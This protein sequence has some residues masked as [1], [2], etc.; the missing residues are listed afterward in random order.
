MSQEPVF[1][2]SSMH[3][4]GTNLLPMRRASSEYQQTLASPQ[5]PSAQDNKPPTILPGQNI[6]N[7]LELLFPK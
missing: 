6:P 2:L 1:P 4:F 7:K 3:H 5:P